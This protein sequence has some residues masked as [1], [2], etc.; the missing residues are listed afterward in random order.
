MRKSAELKLVSWDNAHPT[1]QGRKALL[2]YALM[3]VKHVTGVIRKMAA[4]I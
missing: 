1:S 3:M 2:H 4:R